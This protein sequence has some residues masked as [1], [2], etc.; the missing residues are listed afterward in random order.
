M[1]P[2]L[3]FMQLYQVCHLRL[4]PILCPQR[5]GINLCKYD[6]MSCLI[7]GLHYLCRHYPNECYYWKHPK[8]HNEARKVPFQL[9]PNPYPYIIVNIGSGVSILLVNSAKDF[10]R[11]GGTSVG[12]GTFVGLCS[13]LAG[14]KSFEEA[15]SLA[16]KGDS[17]RVD[18]LVRD[19][20]GGGYE[21]YGL[22][23]DV[24]ASRYAHC[25]SCVC[26]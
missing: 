18:K 15:I 23:G 19:I 9:G 7:R 2:T 6:E 5:L 20:Y 8:V 17:T 10:K 14:A 25:V 3:T 4:A 11:I 22:G 13:L 21:K 16:E 26:V 12:G 24:V 1:V